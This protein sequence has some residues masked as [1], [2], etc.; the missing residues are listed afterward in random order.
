MWTLRLSPAFSLT[1]GCTLWSVIGCSILVYGWLCIKHCY[2]WGNFQFLYFY[3]L[4]T[5]LV[6]INRKIVMSTFVLWVSLLPC[7]HLSSKLGVSQSFAINSEE[8][9]L[10]SCWI[11]LIIY[12]QWFKDG[13]LRI[14]DVYLL[15][16][17]KFKGKLRIY[18]GGR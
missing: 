15:V 6:L 5:N 4:C 7:V 2:S 13:F 3:S 9:G 10:S 17:H 1:A 18:R 14:P 16:A 11:L 12:L 8:V